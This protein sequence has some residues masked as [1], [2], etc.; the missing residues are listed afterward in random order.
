MSLTEPAE[1]GL[2][3]PAH[4][5]SINTL[6]CAHNA[7]AWDARTC[8]TGVLERAPHRVTWQRSMGHGHI[9]FGSDQLAPGPS[10]LGSNSST[11]DP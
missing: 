11:E 1:T 4:R 5:W 3:R 8:Q 6:E 9:W 7:R 2:T 10:N